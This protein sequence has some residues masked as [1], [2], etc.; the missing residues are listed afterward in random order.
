M[1]C[2]DPIWNRLDWKTRS[3]VLY[4][5][6]DMSG[7]VKHMVWLNVESPIM[8]EVRHRWLDRLIVRIEG[9]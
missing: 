6:E 7:E 3:R 4:F 2:V 9:G 5:S 8:W 1:K